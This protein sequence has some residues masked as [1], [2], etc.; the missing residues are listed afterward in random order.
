MSSKKALRRIGIL[1]AFATLAAIATPALAVDDAGTTSAKTDAK[2]HKKNVPA[3][4]K[5]TS[6]KNRGNSLKD[7][8]TTK[9]YIP[10]PA[11]GSGY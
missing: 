4:D 3:Q 2:T 10:Q 8:D 1:A 6:Q 5:A 11:P 9:D 7:R